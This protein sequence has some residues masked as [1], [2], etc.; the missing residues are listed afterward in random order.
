MERETLS[1]RDRT[2]CM[3]SLSPAKRAKAG[4]RLAGAKG[5]SRRAGAAPRPVAVAT[6][7]RNC[8]RSTG[9]VR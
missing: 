6:T 4:L 3:A 8:R 9:L 5:A 7:P 1:M 2:C